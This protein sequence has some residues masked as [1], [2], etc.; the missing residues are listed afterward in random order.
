MKC[1]GFGRGDRKKLQ[2]TCRY[3]FA[4]TLTK[5]TNA[6]RTATTIARKMVVLASHP[7]KGNVANNHNKA[8]IVT[9]TKIHI[10]GLLK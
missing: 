2:V 1:P 4:G 10:Y 9:P 8:P 3:L 6:V 5:L 7:R